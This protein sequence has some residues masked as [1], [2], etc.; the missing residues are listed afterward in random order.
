M[1]NCKTIR[2][3]YF[4]NNFKRYKV[5]IRAA[6][7]WL[8]Y[9]CKETKLVDSTKIVVYNEIVFLCRICEE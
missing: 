5:I 7:E 4:W 9:N 3:N 6:Y 2:I 1:F 8:F